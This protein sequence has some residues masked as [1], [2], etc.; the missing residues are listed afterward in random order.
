[1]PASTRRTPRRT[2][3]NTAR[4]TAA[5]PRT[6]EARARRLR[7]LGRG[8]PVLA[9]VLVLA[10]CS[11]TDRDP[12]AG[13]TVTAATSAEPSASAAPSATAEASPTAAPATTPA[14]P[15]ESSEDDTDAPSEPP[16]QGT[17]GA[18]SLWGTRYQ[19]TAEVSVDAYDSC[20]AGGSRHFAGTR[21]YSVPATLDL[22]RP[23]EGGGQSEDN[24]FSLV[25]TVGAP[26]QAGALSLWSAGVGTGSGQDLAGNPRDP[27]VLLVYWDLDWEG[28]RLTGRLT[29]THA[30]EGTTLNLLNWPGP[31]VPC[32]PDLG[33]L[34]G[35]FPHAVD[36]GTTI[37]GDLDARGASLTV[38]GSTVQDS[39]EFGLRFTASPK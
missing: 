24:P 5:P 9:A 20:G 37:E 15:T 6:S 35:G 13:P 2:S 39:E 1:M 3:G 28:G 11:G 26:T 34:P 8:G 38:K 23:R 32:R 25:L 21:T 4:H 27:R 30:A 22:S 7:H 31:L 16:G 10:A 19:G 12:D 18:Q 36:T 29:D 33:T 14:T 17:S